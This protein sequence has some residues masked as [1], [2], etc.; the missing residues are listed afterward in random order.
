MLIKQ[1]QN[2]CHIRC[3][4]TPRFN[5]IKFAIH[6][7]PMVHLNVPIVAP[8]VQ[9]FFYVHISVCNHCDHK[10]DGSKTIVRKKK[11]KKKRNTATQHTTIRK[12]FSRHTWMSHKSIALHLKNYN[13]GLNYIQTKLW[14]HPIISFFYYSLCRLLILQFLTECTNEHI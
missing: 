2:I 1:L 13:P 9:Q 3:S 4:V 11:K 12:Q 14:T 7:S 5:Y 8:V 6:G 10:Q